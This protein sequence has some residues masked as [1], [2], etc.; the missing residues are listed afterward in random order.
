MDLSTSGS[1]NDFGRRSRSPRKM[2]GFR[3]SER[4]SN[5]WKWR[6]GNNRADNAAMMVGRSSNPN[7]SNDFDESDNDGFE[8]G[9]FRRGGGKPSWKRRG[10]GSSARSGPAE[11]TDLGVRYSVVDD[12]RSDVIVEENEDE[13]SSSSLQ[14]VSDAGSNSSEE[15]TS[16]QKKSGSSARS[17]FSSLECHSRDL[18][19]FP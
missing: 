14:T 7:M 15:F 3:A 18:V 2:V 10:S 12:V 5:Q 9:S 1:N 8:R 4:F 16:I 11:W 17:V 6:E 19:Q 13:R